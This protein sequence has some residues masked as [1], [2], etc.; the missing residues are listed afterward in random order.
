MIDQLRRAICVVTVLVATVFVSRAVAQTPLRIESVVPLEKQ[1]HESD[2]ATIWYDDFNGTEKPYGEREGE[3]D[4]AESFGGSGK[5]LLGFYAKGSQGAGNRKIF[6]GDSPDRRNVVRRGEKFE[7]IYWRI[8][9]KHQP[10]WTGGGEAKLSRT[11]SLTSDKWTQAM[12]AHVWSGEGASLTLDPASGVRGDRVVT[13]RYN[14]FANLHWL[15]SKPSSRFQFSSP[16][17]GG[18]WVCVEARAKL[19]TPGK[20]DGINQL[21]IDGK[22]EAERKNLDWRG[23]YAAFRHQRRLSRILLEPGLADR[24]KAMDR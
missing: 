18:W 19:N 5:S 20:K 17:E 6:F 24:T 4:S 21:W 12:I 7:E 22:L 8:Y 3:L 10:N 9:V 1:P 13:T 11:T 14:D 15:G 2:P 16:E 23:S